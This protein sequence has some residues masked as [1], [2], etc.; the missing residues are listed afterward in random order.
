MRQKVENEVAMKEFAARIGRLVKGGELFELIGDVGAG[1]TTFTKGLATGMGIAETVQSP[2]FTISR[3]YD[4]P[5][6]LRLKHYDFY[7]LSEAGIMKE[8]VAEAVA[9][10]GVVTVVEW[11]EVVASVLPED[12]IRLHIAAVGEEAREI[13]I[14][15]SG[16]GSEKLLELAA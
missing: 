13:I 9:E 11:A 12:R 1:K 10:E 2:T 3:V 16:L 6:G 5:G 4:A 14:T 7:R 15:A 8:D